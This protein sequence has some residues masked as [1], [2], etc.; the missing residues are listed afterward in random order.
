MRAAKGAEPLPIDPVKAFKEAQERKKE[1]EK[2]QVIEDEW[3]TFEKFDGYTDAE[4]EEY[5]RAVGDG[6][7]G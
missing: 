7:D 6:K 1:A 5:K 4:R 3:E 2:A